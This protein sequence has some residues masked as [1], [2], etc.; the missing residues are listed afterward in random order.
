MASILIVDDDLQ[1]RASLEAVLR[2]PRWFVHGAADG[3]EA[4]ASLR[5]R[6]FDVVLLDLLLPRVNGFEVIQHLKALQPETLRKLI[7]LTGAADP[8]LRYFDFSQIHAIL[9][10]PVDGRA[11]VQMVR[12]CVRQGRGRKER[13]SARLPAGNLPR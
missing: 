4:I 11:L 5:Q 7:V 6:S 12:A 10:K 8:T 2:R 3:E 13:V 9:R 1:T